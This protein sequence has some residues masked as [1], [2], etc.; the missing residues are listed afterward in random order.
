MPM[1]LLG[2]EKFK[3]YRLYSRPAHAPFLWYRAL[4]TPKLAFLVLSPFLVLPRYNPDISDED[5]EFLG[6]SG[7]QDALTFNIV[8][9]RG[10]RD[11]TIN[12]KGPILM[13]RHTLQAKQ[14]IPLNA[15]EFA[16]AHPL[17]FK[18]H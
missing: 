11:A 12:L 17:P 3:R 14:V 2:F 6:L 5:A 4:D 7:P 13:N 1:G 18:A 8:T 15:T 9:I 10:P 16:V